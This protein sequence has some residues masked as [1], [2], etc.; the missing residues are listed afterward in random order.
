MEKDDFTKIAA[1]IHK[2]NFSK[3]HEE[4]DIKNA[5]YIRERFDA[6][7]YDRIL[8]EITN[9]INSDEL[10]RKLLKEYAKAKDRNIKELKQCIYNF[11]E[12]IKAMIE[13][14]KRNAK[15]ARAM[16]WASVSLAIITTL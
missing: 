9:K 6:F 11:D 13:K 10:K 5:K 15:K 1:K 2:D 12:K 7:D 16:I 4:N 14:E 8:A 3:W